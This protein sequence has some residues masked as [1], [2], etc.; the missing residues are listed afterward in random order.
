ML[1][2]YQVYHGKQVGEFRDLCAAVS[3]DLVEIWWDCSYYWRTAIRDT[4]SFRRTRVENEEADL[5]FM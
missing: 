5:P 1:A 3:Y 4:S 2:V